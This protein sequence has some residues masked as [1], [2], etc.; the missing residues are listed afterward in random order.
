MNNTTDSQNLKDLWTD[1]SDY[2]RCYQTEDDVETTL[3]LLDLNGA[4][5][6]VDVGCGNGAFAVTAARRYPACRVWAFDALRSAVDE[7]RARGGDLP[8]SNLIADV[9]W[10]HALP[11]PGGCADR[12]L[13][14][15]VLHHLAEP[16][17]VYEE[18]ARVLKPGGCLV[19]Q[20]P[21]NYW[22]PAFADVL[23]GVMRLL[24]DTH[25]R[26]YYRPAEVVAGLERAGF[27][28]AE[29][30]CWTYSFPFLGDREAKFVREHRAEHRLCLRPIGPG[31]WSMDNYWVRVVA[32]KAGVSDGA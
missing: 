3:R 18:I 11:L 6:L 8:A 24:D 27:R 32:A 22:E 2:R 20:A 26:F 13:C 16:H 4:R 25:P 23:S 10:A 9:A 1:S 15:S 21:C 17:L 5:G 12:A 30:E 19:L 31:K 28:A 29:P 14:R 7:C